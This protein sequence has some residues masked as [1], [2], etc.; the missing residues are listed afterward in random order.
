MIELGHYAYLLDE[1]FTANTVKFQNQINIIYNLIEFNESLMAIKIGKFLN[2]PFI[3]QAKDER[4]LYQVISYIIGSIMGVKSVDKNKINSIS[5][6]AKYNEN[7]LE[8]LHPEDAES[9]IIYS[10]AKEYEQFQD[11][12]YKL[13]KSV[14]Y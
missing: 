6:W 2:L 14:P 13:F 10:S 9:S 1:S 8:Y 3:K 12:I 5:Q 7:M 11:Q 4:I